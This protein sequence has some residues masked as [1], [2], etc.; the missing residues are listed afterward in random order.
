MWQM[1]LPKHLQLSSSSSWAFTSS[2][3]QH[4]H[5]HYQCI[6]LVISIAVRF[7]LSIATHLAPEGEIISAHHYV[8]VY[9]FIA[10]DLRIELLSLPRSFFQLHP[11]SQSVSQPVIVVDYWDAGRCLERHEMRCIATTGKALSK[12]TATASLGAF[13]RWLCYNLHL[14]SERLCALCSVPEYANCER[15]IN[16]Y[17]LLFLLL[18]LFFLLLFLLLLLNVNA[19]TKAYKRQIEPRPSMLLPTMAK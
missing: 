18:L 19:N 10:L 9:Y 15:S 1:R 12:W 7:S 17:L 13:A 5:H 3:A 4:R 2:P 14:R 8:L 6:F 16:K 11:A